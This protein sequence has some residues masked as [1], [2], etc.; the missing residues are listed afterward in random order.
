MNRNR[1]NV[2][3]ASVFALLNSRATLRDGEKYA[4]Q[5]QNLRQHLV[6]PTNSRHL[7]D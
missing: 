2:F 1:T 5:I 6:Q 3:P 4:V 7:G